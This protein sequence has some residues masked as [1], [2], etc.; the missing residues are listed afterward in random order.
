MGGAGAALTM[1][2]RKV[3]LMWPSSLMKLTSQGSRVEGREG[4]RWKEREGVQ[5]MWL[6]LCF[7]CMA[8]R[9][10]EGIVGERA[11]TFC[12]TKFKEQTNRYSVQQEQKLSR[13]FE[14]RSQGSSELGS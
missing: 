9:R 14:L 5:I 1:W 3:K 12:L 8:G 2:A 10:R 7:A 11:V 4:R 13:S 6:L